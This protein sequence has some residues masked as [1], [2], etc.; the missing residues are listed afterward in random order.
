MCSIF[1]LGDENVLFYFWTSKGTSLREATSFD[2]L[3]VKIGA[4]RLGR[5]AMEE[6][7]PVT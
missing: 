2:I 6:S 3:I 5:W 7:T 4:G 1:L